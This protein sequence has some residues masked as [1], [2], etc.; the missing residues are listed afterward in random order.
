MMIIIQTT[1]Q[2][3]EVGSNL[4]NVFSYVFSQDYIYLIKKCSKNGNIVTYYNWTVLVRFK[5]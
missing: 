3:L 1:V 2:I 5:M 4:S